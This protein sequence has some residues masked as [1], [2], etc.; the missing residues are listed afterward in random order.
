MPS[1]SLSPIVEASALPLG[2]SSV[3]GMPVVPSDCAV[4]LGEAALAD[5]MLGTLAVGRSQVVTEAEAELPLHPGREGD[6]A[7]ARSV[8]G[9]DDVALAEQEAER[10]VVV[11]RLDCRGCGAQVPV[12]H[13][14]AETFEVPD[15][16]AGVLVA[17]QD[18]DL[19][20]KAVAH[21]PTPASPRA[22]R[23]MAARVRA[24]AMPRIPYMTRHGR[25][26]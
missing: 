11:G 13:D 15:R 5:A 2:E 1:E 20:E 8:A 23:M 12:E 6:A 22:I 19:G 9:A 16:V 17:A 25:G 21:S 14:P 3:Q 10:L 26:S 24:K 7:T 4:E 18:D